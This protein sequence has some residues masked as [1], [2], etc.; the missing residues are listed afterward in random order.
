[1]YMNMYYLYYLN[2]IIDTK[3]ATSTEIKMAE[4]N[5]IKFINVSAYNVAE[6]K[7]LSE[8]LQTP[9]GKWE[10]VKMAIVDVVK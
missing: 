5:L 1:M 2:H 3:I 9:Q 6:A 8:Y 7:S 10:V 4:A